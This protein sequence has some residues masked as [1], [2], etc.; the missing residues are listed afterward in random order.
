VVRP[1][2]NRC[3]PPRAV[4]GA[5][6]TASARVLSLAATAAAVAAALPPAAGAAT[7]R[8][9]TTY[10]GRGGEDK[11]HVS[12][13]YTAA[14]GEAND[15]TVTVE[16]RQIT[17]RDSAGIAPG[18]GCRLPDPSDR[19]LV[20][21]PIS[22]D[23]ILGSRPAV[24]L[25]D[26]DDRAT[27][28]AGDVLFD[29]GAGNDVLRAGPAGAVL[30]GGPGNDQLFG[31]VGRDDF[32]EDSAANGSDTFVGGGGVDKVDYSRRR[33]GVRLDLDGDR[34]DGQRGERDQIGSDV[35]GVLGGDGD[36]RLR[37][38]AGSNRLTG[39]GGSDRVSGGG[40]DDIIEGTSVGTGMDTVVAEPGDRDRLSGG[41]GDDYINGGEATLV[42][43]GGRGQDQ[44]EGGSRRDSIRA[45][46]GEA[47]AVRCSG[48][49]DRV[50][51]DGHDFVSGCE[52]IRRR[53]RAA[54]VLATVGPVWVNTVSPRAGGRV[55]LSVGC[56]T[57]G[58]RVCRGRLRLLHG[59]RKIHDKAFRL[60]R[61][62]T[63][64]Q[65]LRISD[66]LRGQVTRDRRVTLVS[67]ISSRGRRGRATVRRR[68]LVLDAAPD[69]PY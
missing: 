55:E 47:D 2:R 66:E 39:G 29:G 17:F 49:R 11:D 54:A 65:R 59:G 28:A 27:A 68:P 3:G 69:N 51:V 19:T 37:G 35:E 41:G 60:R 48:G 40:G 57:D 18:T 7:A 8:V 32:T 23:A 43:N 9:D 33:R 38:N 56:P 1:V 53:G 67:R 61:G 30:I 26:R 14:G 13:W 46:D 64:G 4:F 58:P 50:S 5:P 21:C 15:L 42:I 24:A 45:G 16:D 36:D 62:R 22:A 10:D 20:V 31:G 34:D 63:R 44:I 52:R 25:G 12:V 6:M